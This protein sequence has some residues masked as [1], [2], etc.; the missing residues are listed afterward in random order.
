MT[1]EQHGVDRTV[2]FAA[3][4]LVGGLVG[5]GVALLL[6]PQSGRRTRRKLRHKA[7]DLSGLAEEKVQHA[8]QDARRY[9]EDARRKVERSGEKVKRR[10][11]EEGEKLK[12]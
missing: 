6:A 8:A 1:E 4:M 11:Q 5:A 9:A 10:V 2:A 12:L 3:G 7:E